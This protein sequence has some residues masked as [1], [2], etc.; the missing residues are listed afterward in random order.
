MSD[1]LAI[2]FSGVTTWPQAIVAIV[3]G[4]CVLAGMI[5]LNDFLHRRIVRSKMDEVRDDLKAELKTNHGSTSTGNAIDRQTESLDRIERRFGGVESDIR[6]IRKDI[7][8][9]TDND[10]DQDKRL[11]DLEGTIPPRSPWQVP[12][13][14]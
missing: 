12:P 1:A 5:F 13:K 7:G 14:S 6:G 2:D 11:R 8:R 9:L 10:G 4:V 3:V